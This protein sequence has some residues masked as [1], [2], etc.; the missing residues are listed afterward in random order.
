[1]L[2]ISRETAVALKSDML[3]QKY[4]QPLKMSEME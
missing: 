1:M 3:I 2:L 4:C